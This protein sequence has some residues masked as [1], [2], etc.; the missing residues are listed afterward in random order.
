MKQ[1]ILTALI[2][3]GIL[4]PTLIFYWSPLM[5]VTITALCLAGTYELLHCIGVHK[6][7]ALSVPFYILALITPTVIRYFDFFFGQWEGV[8]EIYALMLATLFILMIYLFAIVV[9][10]HR[11]I[12]IREIGVAYISVP[13]IIAGFSSIIILCD[14]Q[15]Y[16]KY[17]YL[18]GVIVA[19]MSD[20]FAYFFGKALGKHKLIPEISPKKTVEGSIAGIVG[21]TVCLVIYGF[22]IKLIEKDM[23]INFVVLIVSGVLIAVA[24]QIGD[25]VMSAIKR[26][27]NQKDFG[28]IFPG[29]GGVL[30]RFDSV[31]SVSI[32]LAVFNCIFNLFV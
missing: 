24:S 6:K 21:G 1:R 27:Y 13:Y 28:K 18:V 2:L 25:L 15:P 17:L 16:G 10:S 22:I 5:T 4:L 3:F 19:L 26:T 31:I 30:D 8:I 20:I 9:F 12:T 23:Q 29:H 7:Y 11:D 14:K 32:I